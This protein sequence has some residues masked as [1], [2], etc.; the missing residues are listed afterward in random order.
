M[1]GIGFSLRKMMARETLS[2]TARTYLY[3]AMISSGPLVLS[4]FGILIVGLLSLPIVDHQQSIIQFQV[5]VTYLIALSL[6]LT[7]PLQLLFTRFVSDRIFEKRFDLVF[8]NYNGVTVATTGVSGLLAYGAVAFGF[9]HAPLCYRILMSLGFV[10]L[11]NVW[12]AVIF[13]SSV[14]QYRQILLVFAVAYGC[15]VMFSMGLS[16]YGLT[17]LLAGFVLGQAI[18]LMGMTTLIYRH[19]S[20]DTFICFDVF[21]RRYTYPSLAAVGLLFNL[22]VWLD[23]FMFWYMPGTGAPVIGPLHASVIYDLPTFLAY[24][25]VMPGMATFL[26]RIETDFVEYYEAFYDAVRSDATLQY[27]NSMRDMMVNSVRAG[28]YEII[29]VQTVVLLLVLAWGER[30]LAA[31]KISV[32]YMPL[33]LIDVVS[34]SLQV[35]FLGLL[36]VFFYLDGRRTVLQ[37]TAAFVIL[38]GAFTAITLRI[39]PN[40]YGYGFALSLLAVVGAAVILLDRR[41]ASLEYETYM[42]GNQSG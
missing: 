21:N 25:C 32:L 29:K 26:V 38:N 23:K 40:A 34:A 35:L 18:L 17:G 11:S 10:I 12:I 37:L 8:S 3:A 31:L 1:A 22:G 24:L 16:R 28:L 14:K 20:S 30:A 27:I 42:L 9:P 13:L 39:G 7:G 19:Y 4:I 15:T 36:N 2:G 33:L 6:I 41:F 5:S